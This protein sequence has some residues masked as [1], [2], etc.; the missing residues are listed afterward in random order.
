MASGSFR[1][2][3]GFRSVSRRL[4][5]IFQMTSSSAISPAGLIRCEGSFRNPWA[6]V[7]VVERELTKHLENQLHEFECNRYLAPG[8]GLSRFF[9]EFASYSG[10]DAPSAPDAHIRLFELQGTAGDIFIGG[11]DRR[12]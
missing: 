1:N 9:R 8:V 2:S 12:R 10:A 6:T 7:W 3:A 11:G 4:A 5:S